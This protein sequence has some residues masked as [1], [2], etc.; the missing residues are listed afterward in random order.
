LIS[1]RL[2]IADGNIFQVKTKGSPVTV[3]R[4]DIHMSNTGQLE[5]WYRPGEVDPFYA[6]SYQ[7]ALDQQ[8]IGS[9]KDSMTSLPSFASSIVIPA[10]TAYTFYVTGSVR[11]SIS[12]WYDLGTEVGQTYASD[13]YLE[14]GSGY[15]LAYAFVGHSSPRNWNG[16]FVCLLAVDCSLSNV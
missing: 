10:N 3:E 4:L 2:P 14:I 1:K 11:D 12:I 5:V 9:G 6:D 13:E 7:N 15:A 16:T 8:T